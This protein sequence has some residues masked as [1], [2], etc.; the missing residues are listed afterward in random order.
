MPYVSGARLG[1]VILGS[2]DPARL[3]A[4]YQ[5]AFAPG[6]AIVDSVLRLRMGALVFEQR[7]DVGGRAAEPGRIVLN[8]QVDRFPALEAHLRTL[9]VEWLRAPEQVPQGFIGTLL[10]ADGN[11]VNVIEITG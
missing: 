7:E 4:W 8:V 5:A 3:A 10:D 2:A 1:S 9:G 11:L 6:V